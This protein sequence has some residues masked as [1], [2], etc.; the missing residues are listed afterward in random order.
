MYSALIEI[1]STLA[2]EAK[3]RVAVSAQSAAE[4]LR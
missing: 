2:A 1:I 4:T 3:R